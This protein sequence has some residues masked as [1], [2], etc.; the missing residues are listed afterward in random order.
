[1][2]EKEFAG[3]GIK[4]VYH[5]FKGFG[6]A[7]NEALASGTVDFAAY[8]DLCGVV[9]RAGGLKIHVLAITGGAG[10]T[11]IVVPANSSIKSF[12]GLKGKKVALAKGT[13]MDLSFN[14]MI[15]DRGFSEKD[16]KI[17]NLTAI[18]GLAALAGGSVDAQ[19]GT[20]AA[21]DLVNRGQLKVIYSTAVPGVPDN[22]MAFGEIVVR[23]DFEKKYPG[24]VKRVIK[25]I[26][27]ANL[28]VSDEKNREVV[29]KLSEK[30]GVPPELAKQEIGNK[31]LRWINGLSMDCGAIARLKETVEFAK[32]R[33][34]IRADIDVEEWV[35]PQYLSDAYKELGVR[36]RWKLPASEH[37]IVK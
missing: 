2:F 21:L 16:F 22:Y 17:Y 33:G 13:Y 30:T 26:A 32:K 34:M 28:F 12:D 7:A 23:D 14:R 1:M 31:R 19:V 24:L 11:Y 3:D 5:L 27:L 35:R 9:S 29:L 37:Y 4:V 20:Y 6:P 18:D 15:S 10:D 25:V 8:G 36:D